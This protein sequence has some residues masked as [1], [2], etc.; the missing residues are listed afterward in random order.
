MDEFE[1][2]FGIQSCFNSVSKLNK[3]VEKTEQMWQRTL[4]FQAIE[5]AVQEGIYQN[6]RFTREFLTGGTKDSGSVIAFVPLVLFK[7]KVRDHLLRVAMPQEN[8]DRQ[9]IITIQEKTKTYATYRANAKTHADETWIGAMQKSSVLAYR[10][11]QAA[12]QI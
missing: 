10:I 6:N 8:L 2:R 3:V 1:K 5:Y 12:F 11:I 9:D 4:V 7:W